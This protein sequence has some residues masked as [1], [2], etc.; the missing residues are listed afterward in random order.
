M[1]LF[2]DVTVCVRQGCN[3]RVCRSFIFRFYPF[4]TTSDCTMISERLAISYYFL[5]LFLFLES[6]IRVRILFS[7]F[8]KW[9]AS[10]R[11]KTNKKTDHLML[12]SY[13][14]SSGSSLL[15]L[16]LCSSVF[17]RCKKCIY[18]RWERL[19]SGHQFFPLPGSSTSQK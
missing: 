9:K 12:E 10:V 13:H 16:A 5:F 7:I 11:F 1:S 14:S 15:A 2:S 8:T 4:N 19:C 17:G 18:R 6:R 3:Q